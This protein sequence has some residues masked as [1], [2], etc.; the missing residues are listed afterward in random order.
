ME[1]DNLN[2]YAGRWIARVRGQIIAQ[3][4][5]PEQARRAARGTRFKET[6]EIV[7]MPNDD[8]L[9]FSPLLESVRTIL[10]DDR[11]VYLVGGAVRDAF[12]G[13]VSHDLDFALDRDGIKTARRVASGLKADFYPLDP[14]RDTGRVIVSGED[15]THTF[16]DFATFR[17]PD[18]ETDLAGRDFTVNAIA[19]DVHS[20]ALHDPLGGGMD[21]KE[22][23]LRAC[24]SAA[25]KEDPVRILR[26]VRQAAEFGFHIL[27]ETRQSMKQAVDG[28]TRISPER[29]RDE[30]FRILEGPQPGTCIS[31][32]ELLGAL[33]KILPEISALKGVEQSAP[34]VNDVWTHTLAALRY[35]ESSLGALAASYQPEAAS[36]W[37][38]GLLVLRLGRFRQKFAE[39]F[40]TP[41][42]VNRSLRGLIFM[43]VLFHDVGKPACRNV[44]A[45]GQV[46]FI[47]HDQRGAELAVE[48]ARQLTMSNDEIERLDLVIRNHM[49]IHYLADRL[50]KE[51]KAPTRRSI[52]RF[53]R[54]A[55]PAGVDLVL[56]ALADCRATYENALPQETWTAYL[57]V[58]RTLLENWWEK[59]EESIAPPPL[60][61]GSE[62]MLAFKLQPGPRLGELLEAVREAQAAGKIGKREEAIAFA[63][64][65]ISKGTQRE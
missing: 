6:P 57:D 22:K 50:I 14:E 7:F 31:A 10:P 46:R 34:H 58:C 8:A 36:D 2:P 15:G 24:S 54:D 44:E 20:R 40:G 32:L 49:R 41:L 28:I 43:E 1:G 51:Q 65:F 38:H 26:G 5:T 21:L 25:F 30:F 39:Y 12:L 13:R 17:G 3:G 42:N 61:N 18:L 27:A 19:M 56:L 11:V 45:G 33:E 4:G 47:G 60:V 59:P 63:R 35:L 62:L 16:M 9:T 64:D 55:G 23:R 53:F 52:Y 37:Y 29:L 48:R